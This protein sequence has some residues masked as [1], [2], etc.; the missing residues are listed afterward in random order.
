MPSAQPTEAVSVVSV[1]LIHDKAF[2][3]APFQ[4]PSAD[5]FN[6][7]SSHVHARSSTRYC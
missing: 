5:F 3:R 4:P 7:F 1:F 2:S 6:T